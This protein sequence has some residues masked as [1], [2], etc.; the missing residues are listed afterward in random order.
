[1]V[2]TIS[3]IAGKI[4]E[5]GD[6][7]Y[8]VYHV[9]KDFAFL[10]KLNSNKLDLFM[11]L[12]KTLNEKIITGEYQI[13]DPGPSMEINEGKMTK[14][15]LRVYKTRKAFISDLDKIYG[16][17]FMEL[18]S[19]GHGEEFR[20]LYDKHGISKKTAWK[21]VRLYLQAGRCDE[22]LIDGRIRHKVSKKYEYNERTGRPYRE[23][24]IVRGLPLTEELEN[25]FDEYRKKF[26]KNKSMTLKETYDT[27]IANEFSDFLDDGS[28][29]KY[30]EGKR[31]TE[32]QFYYFVRKHTSKQQRD[33]AFEGAR[34]VRNNKRVLVGSTRAEVMR[35]G[36]VVEL[37]TLEA[38]IS[39]VSEVD[40]SQSIG[41]GILYMAVDVLT[42]AI[43]AVSPGLEN[44]SVMGLTSLLLNLFDDKID[45]AAE[46]GIEFT[47]ELWPSNFVPEEFRVDNG[48][49]YKSIDA[50]KICKR[51]G[52]DIEKA[53]SGTGSYKAI[54]EQSFHQFQKSFRAKLDG[55][56]LI[57][58]RYDSKHHEEACMTISEF[59]QMVIAFVPHYNQ[60]ANESRKLE[61]E[62]IENNILPIPIMLW[63]YYAQR[64]GAPQPINPDKKSELHYKL[65]LD[66]K[67]S[68]GRDGITFKGI[69]Y[70]NNTPELLNRMYNAGRKRVPVDIK[71][72]PRSIDNIFYVN[73]KSEYVAASLNINKEAMAS[74]KGMTFHQYEQ[75][76]KKSKAMSDEMHE[77]NLDVNISLNRVTNTIVES[78]TSLTPPAT[79]TKTT[80]MRE[81]REQ[82][83]HR[84]NHENKISK[85]LDIDTT[86]ED[87]EI[88]T[89]TEKS[90]LE[91]KPYESLEEAQLAE[92]KKTYGMDD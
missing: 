19:G 50:K 37:D 43:V 46:Y 82:E 78:A 83:K 2:A 31:P 90:E 6:D 61:K 75:Y 17:D 81:A 39:L 24:T 30:P 64:N 21:I 41:R 69:H 71:Y 5:I 13:S 86:Y 54:I 32:N 4:I 63:K 20:T 16:P 49:D 36:A 76:I 44:N 80:N 62:L 47:K 18:F 65:M 38:D 34:E 89:E 91:L 3:N 35:P 27:M 60:L 58:K 88:N 85:R 12:R 33:I 10:A 77:H 79:K 11:S 23:G 7:K 26:L 67:A 59:T 51:I 48:S 40:R 1:M 70:L 53:P 15:E 92:L 42:G 74:F 87:V 8:K 56:G 68:L 14:D 55:K 29:Q 25:I 72:D 66:G 45:Y 84:V 57:T 9:N 73:D 22:G 28:V 52:I